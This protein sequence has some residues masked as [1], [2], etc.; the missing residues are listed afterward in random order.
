MK[1]FFHKYLVLQT[2]NA[3]YEW[4]LFFFHI[5]H[6]NYDSSLFDVCDRG[7]A[8]VFGNSWNKNEARNFSLV[9]LINLW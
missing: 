3:V 4:L 7:T 9:L 1:F 5:K 8:S 6:F 2:F